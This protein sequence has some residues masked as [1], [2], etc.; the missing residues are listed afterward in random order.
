MV[1]CS[2]CNCL[3]LS[4]RWLSA[5]FRSVHSSLSFRCNSRICKSFSVPHPLSFCCTCECS[6][7]ECKRGKHGS[8]GWDFSSAWI[9]R[10]SIPLFVSSVCKR[11]CRTCSS[12]VWIRMSSS[13]PCSAR[14]A[15]CLS[16]A[17]AR[18]SLATFFSVPTCCSPTA[19]SSKESRFSSCV[20]SSMNASRL[21]NMH[22]IFETSASLTT[23]D[24]QAAKSSSNASLGTGEPQLMLAS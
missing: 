6:S 18:R 1:S 19:A 21:C 20:F 3:S 7:D 4:M 17:T 22:R 12:A 24:G 23:H 9:R 13:R 14:S 2:V 11:I 5:F 16:P 10:S 8:E 15:R